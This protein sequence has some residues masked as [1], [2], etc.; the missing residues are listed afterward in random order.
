MT[1]DP[2][3]TASYRRAMARAG[4]PA[5]F[6]RVTGFAPNAATFSAKVTAIARDALPDTTVVARTDVPA[7][8]QGAITQ[9]DRIIIV[10]ADDLAQQ[11]F[12]LPL[13][14]HD[15][16]YLGPNEDEYDVISVDAYKL[17]AAGAIEVKVSGVA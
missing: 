3:M 5:K 4:V 15:K 7:S 17:A 8:K 6:M 9:D 10:I 11:R 16:A 1:G 12:P 2:T 14:K 13:Q